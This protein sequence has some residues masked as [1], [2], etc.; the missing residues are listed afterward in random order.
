[1]SSN[2]MERVGDNSYFG[3]GR[4]LN[5]K[6]CSGCGRKALKARRGL[7]SEMLGKVKY[8]GIQREEEEGGT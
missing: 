8:H 3:Q 7:C 4:L 1:M 2:G 5:D 6:F